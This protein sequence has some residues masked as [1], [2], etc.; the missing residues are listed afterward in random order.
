MDPSGGLNPFDTDS[1]I[2]YPPTRRRPALLSIIWDFPGR[3]RRPM[4]HIARRVSWSRRLEE[5]SPASVICAERDERRRSK[6]SAVPGIWLDR[7][8]VRRP[9][10]IVRSLRYALPLGYL[11]HPCTSLYNIS[12]AG[13]LR[14]IDRLYRPTHNGELHLGLSVVCRPPR[15]VYKSASDRS[16]PPLK[17]A[18]RCEAALRNP[19]IASTSLVSLRQKLARCRLTSLIKGNPEPV[20]WGDSHSAPFL[21]PHADDAEWLAPCPQC[22][23]GPSTATRQSRSS[24]QA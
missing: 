23:A 18:A 12:S 14:P 11:C 22:P 24:A 7:S 3:A 6:S 5:A 20:Q 15:D 8:K 1:A 4:Q 17:A 2:H 19:A 9:I 21:S 10:G 16:G 13:C